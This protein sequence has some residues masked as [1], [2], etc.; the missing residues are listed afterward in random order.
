MVF[1]KIFL[2]GLCVFPVLT[3]K[4]EAQ[5]Y[6]DQATPGRGSA[7]VEQVPATARPIPPVIVRPSETSRLASRPRPHQTSV[8]HSHLP[9]VGAGSAAVVKVESDKEE[10][11]TV[12][13]GAVTLN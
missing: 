1:Y 3:A 10:W 11:P 6:L 7:Y 2:V 8:L 5:A 13:K 12:G 9:S 4:C